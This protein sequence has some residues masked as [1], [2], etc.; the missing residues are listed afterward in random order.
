MKYSFES[1]IRYSEVGEN[2]KLTLFGLLNYFQDCTIFHS[3]SIGLGVN[4]LEQAKKIW[5]LQSWQIDIARY[6]QMGERIRVCTWPYGFKGFFGDRNFVMEDESGEPVAWAN[7]VWVF[8]DLETGRPARVTEEELA[9]YELEEKLDMDY[10]DRRVRMP[11]GGR[12]AEPITIRREYLD[13]NHH[14][15][16]G[17]YVRLGQLCLPPDFTVKRLRAEYKSQARLGDVCIPEIVEQDSA[18]YVALK[19]EQGAAYANMEFCSE[20]H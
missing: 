9:G 6:P 5:V 4:H 20:R 16:N 17:Q 13:T 8:M 12:I 19:N 18:V 2:G 3:E 14:V 15:N 10:Q 1:R 7:S 11:E